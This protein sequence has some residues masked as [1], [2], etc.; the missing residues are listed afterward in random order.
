M[1]S[2][3]QPLHAF[4]IAVVAAFSAALISPLA[5][6]ADRPYSARYAATAKGSVTMAGN[7]VLSCPS[8]GAPCSSMQ[9]GGPDAGGQTER[10]FEDVDG[11]AATF[12]SSRARIAL[13][14]GATVLKAYLYW[15][16]DTAASAVVM[17]ATP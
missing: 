8:T 12:D 2:S 1:R 13:P 3:R 10:N 4:L 16:A 15:S 5:A 11:D 9:F 7:T 6:S 14:T 17:S